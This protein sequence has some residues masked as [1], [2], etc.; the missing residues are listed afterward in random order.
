ML[1]WEV[2]YRLHN[3]PDYT[4]DPADFSRLLWEGYT[5]MY[6]MA[7]P[8]RN[9]RVDAADNTQHCP[10]EVRLAAMDVVK[11]IDFIASGWL[12]A[13]TQQ[14]IRLSGTHRRCTL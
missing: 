3:D 9:Q 10:A 1:Q 14:P 13:M 5:V 12:D 8:N 2:Y 7:E 6:L 11:H 4:A